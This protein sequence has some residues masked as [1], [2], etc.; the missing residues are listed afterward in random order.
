M[1][2]TLRPQNFC[3]LFLIYLLSSCATVE[4]P[5]ALAEKGRVISQESVAVVGPLIVID[6]TPLAPLS[7]EPDGV[8][9][10]AKSAAKTE[11]QKL[12][13]KPQA[14][15]SNAKTPSAANKVTQA[16]ALP[17]AQPQTEPTAKEKLAINQKQAP[18][19][20]KKAPIS[21]EPAP[22]SPMRPIGRLQGKISL[23]GEDSEKLKQQGVIVL[24]EPVDSVQGSNAGT[25]MNLPHLIDMKD[26]IYNPSHLI[27]QKNDR[28]SFINKDQI[29]HNVFSSTGKNAFDLGTYG[30]GL[31]REVSLNSTG[32]VKV[33]CNIHPEMATFI[34]VSESG[35]SAITNEQGEFSIEGIP[36]GEYQLKLW[37]IRGETNKVV[38][39]AAGE[40]VS[41]DFT[42]NT[43]NPSSLQH[44]NKHGKKYNK[45]AAIF[46]D[47]FY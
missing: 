21:T 1:L 26:K 5:V 46:D 40:K 13:K 24:M 39:I 14:S 18:L 25:A 8:E 9:T 15:Q 10:E 38:K 37:H 20:P 33:Y 23:I 47:E 7:Q 2:K 3:Y 11:N 44:K 34:G 41:M 43:D 29:K 35:L 30:A 32:V 42:I 31:R 22:A 28:V 16:E 45:N 27:I 19:R 6:A 4:D 17:K 12:T 36:S